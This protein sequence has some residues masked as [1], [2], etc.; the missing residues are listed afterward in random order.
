VALVLAA[1]ACTCGPLTEVASISQTLVAVGGTVE[2][3]YPTLQGQLT[4][5][6]P[7]IAAG[8]TD[9]AE[10]ATQYGPTVIAMETIAAATA[11]AIGGTAQ[12]GGP[13]AYDGGD[14]LETTRV[15]T[16]APGQT[17]TGTLTGLYEAHNWLFEGQA[18]QTVTIT[19]EAVG[20]SDPRLRLLD[21]SGNVIGEADDT[22]TGD[23]SARLTITLPVSGTYTARVDVF[24]AGD[25]RITVQ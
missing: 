20:D 2:E 17:L 3:Y 19:V 1:L 14:G 7:T 18:G 13:P 5:L 16:I 12:P 6:G 22:G 8:A 11:A 25:Y 9:I 21:P 15:E 24:A 4:E 23:L 10:A